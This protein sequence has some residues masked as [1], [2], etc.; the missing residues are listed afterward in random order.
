MKFAIISDTHLGCSTYTDK[1][2]SDFSRQFNRAVELAIDSGVHGIFLLGDIFDSSAYR[3]NVDNFASI[4]GEIAQS[5]VSLKKSEIKI[6]AIAGNHE[7]GRGRGGGEMRILSDLGFLNLLEDSKTEFG[8]YEIVGI[9]WKS[10]IDAFRDAIKKLGPPKSNSILLIHQFCFGSSIIPQM[11]A[12]VSKKDLDGWPTVFCG[13]HHHYENLGYVLIPGS[14]EVQ[15]AKEAGQKGFIIY[16]TDNRLHEFIKLPPSRP[17]QYLNLDANGRTA[18]ELE[19]QIEQWIDYNSSN[20]AL[21]VIELNGRLSSGRSVDINWNQLRSRAIQKGCLKLHIG[22]GLED[23][24]RSAPEI[25]AAT[26]M[27]GFLKER[28][29]DRGK[30]ALQYVQS[31]KEKGDDYGQE[32]LTRII[33]D[34]KR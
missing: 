33:D 10:S 23:Q 32:I 6:F 15:D 13:H 25:R 16:D 14:L 28:F 27:E 21:L 34:L 7:Y 26:S 9:P 29:G 22:G 18:S 1:R 2:A 17:V 30:I 20:G 8:G 24:V 5:L 31:F 3:R 11:I 19:K 12:E 4:L